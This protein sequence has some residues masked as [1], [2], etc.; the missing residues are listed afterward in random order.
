MNGSKSLF[1]SKGVWGAIA[2]I[3][4]MVAH[5]FGL[6]VTPD[7]QA[8]V[9]TTLA[10]IADYG[11]SIVELFGVLLGLYGRITADKKIGNAQ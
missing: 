9:A 1:A 5:W 11:G 10:Q 6:S 2:A 7:D 8:L 3:V 4:G